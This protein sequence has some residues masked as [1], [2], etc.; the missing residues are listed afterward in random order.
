M[1]SDHTPSIPSIRLCI[2]PPT[3]APYLSA[4]EEG[5]VPSDALT[6][7]WCRVQG[8]TPSMIASL[9]Q[10]YRSE[11]G[12]YSHSYTHPHTQAPV[13]LLEYHV[14]RLKTWSQCLHPTV[15]QLSD[16][17]NTWLLHTTTV[18]R[19]WNL[20]HGTLSFSNG[21]PHVMGIL[22]VTPDSFSDG[23]LYASPD[24]A[25]GRALD[26]IEQ[27][28]NLLDIG[29]ESTR[30]GAPPVSASEEIK[31][32]M[33]I[34]ETLIPQVNV[35]ISV[36]TT[37]A[38]VARMALEAGAEI[39]N[40]ISGM[41]FDPDLPEI[42]ASHHGHV[43]SMHSRHTPETMQHRPAYHCFWDEMITE[44]QQGCDK[45]QRAGVPVH[46]I[47]IDPGIGF[48][49]RMQDNY[50]ILRELPVLQQFQSPLVIGASRKSFL[51][52]I[53]NLPASQRLEGSLAAAAA[54]AWHK[55]HILRVHD[56]QET[57]RLLDTCQAIFWPPLPAS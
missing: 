16:L 11:T 3:D 51:G 43:I 38:E 19:P 52:A 13:L 53:L 2:L 41:R 1:F 26:M 10:S 57:R 56:V 55:A 14:Q 24:R 15:P 37:K 6:G 7:W 29:G 36:D 47:A 23:G 45:L 28:A 48:G 46:K 18:P 5:V 12:G 32:I 4:G 33:P 35:P 25:V 40:D 30:P 21:R 50:R 44:L 27:G 39:I 31:R 49:K 9:S 54:S 17:L 20:R 34:L 8:L 42:I 22:N